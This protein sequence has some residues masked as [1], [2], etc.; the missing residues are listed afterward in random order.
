MAAQPLT[1]QDHTRPLSP[2]TPIF[3]LKTNSADP[4]LRDLFSA[5]IIC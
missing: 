2:K 5:S 4:F 1:N 3:I